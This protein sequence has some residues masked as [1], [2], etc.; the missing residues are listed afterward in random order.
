MGGASSAAPRP[1]STKFA[2]VLANKTLADRFSLN[3]PRIN[4][5]SKRRKRRI[6]IIGLDNSGKSTILN[7]LLKRNVGAVTVPTEGFNAESVN[8]KGD[9]GKLELT[10][11]DLGGQDKLRGMWKHY[12]IGVQGVI[13]VVDATDA[14]RLELC[15]TELALCM[16]DESLADAPVLVLANKQDQRGAKGDVDVAAKMGLE[17]PDGATL[18]FM[19]ERQFR[20]FGTSAVKDTETVFVAVEWLCSVM[21]S[22]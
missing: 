19:G 11:W 6:V 12:F 16:Q 21:K 14:D 10:L 5:L 8:Y 1:V 15:G 4:S 17:A 20:V 18:K 13:F 3:L 9:D 7:L 2:P 22:R